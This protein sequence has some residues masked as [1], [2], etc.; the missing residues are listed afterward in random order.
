[1]ATGAASA[2]AAPVNNTA[3]SLANSAEALSGGAICYQAHV[4]KVGWQSV[5]CNGEVAGTTGQSLRLEALR[6]GVAGVGTVCAQAHIQK[7]GWQTPQCTSGDSD[8]TIGT[9]GQSL[10][11]QAVEVWRPT[12][13]T[14]GANG[15]LHDIGWT[16]WVWGNDVL[17]GTVG[18]S[19]PMEAIELGVR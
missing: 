8:I 14:I 12:G 15:H 5:V 6:I 3:T 18:Q 4:Q 9:T 7:L 13:G 1:M 10:A 19:I 16:G 17:V 11:I 2:S